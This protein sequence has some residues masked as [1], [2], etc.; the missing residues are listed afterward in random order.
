VGDLIRKINVLREI[1]A[2]AP[3]SPSISF[4]TLPRDQQRKYLPLLADWFTTRHA[5]EMAE[6]RKALGA[7]ADL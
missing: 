1:T 4:F 3:L 5:T 2:K 7:A 6:L